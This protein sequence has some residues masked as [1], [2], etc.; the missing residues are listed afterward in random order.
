MMMVITAM[1]EKARCDK[2]REESRVMT[3]VQW[4]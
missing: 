4:C 3:L 1:M 2:K